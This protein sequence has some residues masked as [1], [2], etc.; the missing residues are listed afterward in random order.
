M[1]SRSWRQNAPVG[2]GTKA[3]VIPTGSLS[4]NKW[5]LEVFALLGLAGDSETFAG[6]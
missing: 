2:T 6:L 5:F 1:P 3:M 4:A